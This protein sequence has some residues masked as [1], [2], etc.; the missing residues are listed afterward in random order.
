[1][2]TR[3]YEIDYIRVY[4]IVALIV[5][6]AFAPFNTWHPIC[7]FNIEAYGYIAKF[8][9]S[10]MLETFVFISGFLFYSKLNEGVKIWDLV[11]S[12]FTRLLVPCYIFGLLYV[13]LCGTMS[14]SSA[15]S[16]LNGYGHLWFLPMLFWVFIVYYY[17]YPYVKKYVVESSIIIFVLAV[18]PYPSMPMRINNVMYYLAFFHMGVMIRTFDNVK[19]KMTSLRWIHI[20]A[21][22]YI[23]LFISGTFIKE[24]YLLVNPEASILHKAYIVWLSNMSRIVYSIVGVALFYSIAYNVAQA[25]KY[26]MAPVA[27][28]CF[29]VYLFQEII[30]Q[31]LYYK[32]NI[33][34][35]VSPY[36][37]PW[38]A[39]VI[40][41][42]LSL[43]LV[44]IMR[45]SRI[46][47]SM[48]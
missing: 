14:W 24:S 21:I 18:L 33:S 30:L 12:K 13:V 28:L 10:A 39:C 42:T 4:L 17:A 16:I 48:I 43:A 7:D 46:L 35:Y 25:K 38:I 9:Y 44:N 34:E 3:L 8:A 20:L 45:K 31:L 27:N 41:L 29:G 37:S 40:T 36:I 1:M 6:H 2:R 22:L 11:K 26:N 32:M 47:K 23:V 15:Y 19:L 5:C